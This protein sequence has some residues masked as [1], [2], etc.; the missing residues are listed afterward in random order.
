[1]VRFSTHRHYILDGK[2]VDEATYFSIT[3]AQESGMQS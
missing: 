3:Q 1:M 2:I